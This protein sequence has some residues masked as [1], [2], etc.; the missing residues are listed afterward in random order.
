MVVATPPNF[1]QL[2]TRTVHRWTKGTLAAVQDELVME[3]PLELRAHGKTMAIIMRT[4]GHDL[5]LLG[6]L[7]HAEGVLLAGE[8]IG[9]LAVVN[10]DELGDLERGNVVELHLP[11][12]LVRERWA[13]RQVMTSS[14]CG[15]CG[16]SAL[17]VL[18]GLATPIRS[19][20]Q[21]SHKMITEVPNELKRHQAVFER[22]GAL[23]G[24]AI[25]D[26]AG[27]VMVCR[28]DV[29]R[30]NAVDKVVGWAR[31]ND[32]LPLSECVLGVSGRLSYEIVHKAITAGLP[33]VVAVSAP[34]SLAVDLAERWRVTLAG[35]VR[36]EG[37]NVYSHPSRI[38]S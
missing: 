25:F 8:E 9:H 5:E 22:S 33:I 31:Q 19:D 12:E 27:K 37:F 15:V 35:F 3:E 11:A 20:M 23:H 1:E 24:A 26:R 10:P 28:E 30:H 14:A 16:A 32:L 21:W 2:T 7:L 4:L 29:G 17:T 18:D 36:G 38:T 6:G 34:S 13:E